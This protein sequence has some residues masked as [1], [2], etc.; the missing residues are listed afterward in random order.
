M[1]EGY[2]FVESSND[3]SDYER[4]Y[5]RDLDDLKKQLQR[6]TKEQQVRVAVP[7]VL[8][9]GRSLQRSTA[10]GFHAG[11]NNV[12][13]RNENGKSDQLTGYI[14]AYDDMTDDELEIGRALQQESLQ[15]QRNW[16]KWESEHHF[17]LEDALRQEIAGV[18]PEEEVS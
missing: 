17:R 8:G 2:F 16:S 10:I 18:K 12:M 7:F 14:K 6:L 4:V 5:N 3:G 11:T 15:A 13:V 1:P 9:G